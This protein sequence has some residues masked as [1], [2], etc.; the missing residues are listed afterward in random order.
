MGRVTAAVGERHDVLEQPVDVRRRLRLATAVRGHASPGGQGVPA[1]GTGRRGIGGDDL[2]ARL[3]EVVPP[4]DVLRVA[5]ADAEH[6]DRGRHDALVGAV[7]PGVVDQTGVH[8]PVDVGGDGQVDVVGLEAVDHGTALVA[9]G[10]VRGREAHVLALGGLLELLGDRLVGGLGHGEA[11]DAE[12]LLAPTSPGA[13]GRQRH[14]DCRGERGGGESSAGGGRH[15]RPRVGHVFRWR[16][17]GRPYGH[18]RAGI[19]GLSIRPHGRRVR[20]R[21]RSRWG[22]G[23]AATDKSHGPSPPG[24]DGAVALGTNPRTQRF[25]WRSQRCE[26]LM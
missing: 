8:E 24:C 9:G 2:D 6:H 21:G 20:R 5:L 19:R 12:R 26:D 3:H 16:A 25:T 17:S 11:H 18:V 13:A 7:V 14:G 10:A 15:R 1:S 4:L 23:G 22:S